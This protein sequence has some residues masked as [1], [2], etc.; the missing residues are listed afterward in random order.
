MVG[1]Q[2]NGSK[3]K[4]QAVCCVPSCNVPASTSS[5][6]FSEEVS[7][8]SV[9]D[10]D[11]FMEVARRKPPGNLAPEDAL[12]SLI[13]LCVYWFC[14]KK[15]KVL[16]SVMTVPKYRYWRKCSG[17]GSPILGYRLFSFIS[18]KQYLNYLLWKYFYH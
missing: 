17:I 13:R 8:F 16:V 11:F 10:R 7:T 4:R 9:S 1:M 6:A 5:D 3:N 12:G 2:A 18:Q 14:K 15:K